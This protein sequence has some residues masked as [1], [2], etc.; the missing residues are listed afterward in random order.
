MGPRPAV[1]LASPRFGFA[2]FAN[3][4]SDCQQCRASSKARSS[5]TD[6]IVGRLLCRIR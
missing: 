2:D 6:I 1:I 4:R 5:S 3:P